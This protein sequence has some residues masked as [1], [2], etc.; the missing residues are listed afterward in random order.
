MSIN[1]REMSEKDKSAVLKIVRETFSFWE[2]I[3]AKGD[4]NIHFFMKK[5][6]IPSALKRCHVAI[7][8]G[9]V[10]GTVGYYVWR[11]RYWLNWFCVKPKYQ[12][13]GIGSTLIN[14]V[15]KN[16]KMEGAK[17]LWVETGYEPRYGRAR[18][19]YREKGF[20]RAH[21]F[22]ARIFGKCLLV[23]FKKLH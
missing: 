13:Q 1:Y 17:E 18:K 11:K 2:Y 7:K 14:L 10:I 19:F 5:L 16:V 22:Y 23:L 4:F 12:G 3:L 15:E 6:K 9:K 21:D 8:N 20:L